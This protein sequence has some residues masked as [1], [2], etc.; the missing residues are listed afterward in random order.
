MENR[1]IE[2]NILLLRLPQ[3]QEIV[4]Y[5]SSTIYQL[6][7]EGKFPAPVKLGPRASAWLESEIHDWINCRIA[8]REAMETG[9]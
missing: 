8:E 3:V 7:A 4:P 6:I 1:T 9:S 2:P 5:S